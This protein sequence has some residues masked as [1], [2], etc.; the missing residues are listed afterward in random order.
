MPSNRVSDCRASGATR[1][2]G[3]PDPCEVKQQQGTM[4]QH[5]MTI[6]EISK[7]PPPMCE[8]RVEKRIKRS[9][10]G[11]SLVSATIRLHL[12]PQ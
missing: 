12:F 10:N 7:L 6:V 4:E 3:K 2:E 11:R 1:N 9:E 8:L 5:K